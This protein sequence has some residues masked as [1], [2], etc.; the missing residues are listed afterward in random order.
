MVNTEQ[1]SIKVVCPECGSSRVSSCPGGTCMSS[2]DDVDW[3]CQECL[4][5]FP[6]PNANR[7]LE[8][9]KWQADKASSQAHELRVRLH[10]ERS[11]RYHILRD[12][13]ELPKRLK[14]VALGNEGK[15]LRLKGFLSTARS[16]S[17]CFG[18]DADPEGWH[19]LPLEFYLNI[20][21][22]SL[23]TGKPG[24]IAVLPKY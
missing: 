6:D 9:Q 20:D 8:R 24:G 18:G 14:F 4:N 19:D 13:T 5:E 3:L 16:V 11:K 21:L 22:E 12:S 15:T 10:Q 23:K 17:Q 1:E 7:R 2:M